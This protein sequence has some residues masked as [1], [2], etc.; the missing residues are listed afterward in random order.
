[1]T[2]KISVISQ[3][4]TCIERISGYSENHPNPIN[5]LCGLQCRVTECGG[6]GGDIYITTGL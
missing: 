3:S 4:L 1:M 5:A 6:G 2:F